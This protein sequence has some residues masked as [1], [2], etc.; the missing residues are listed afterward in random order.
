[1]SRRVAIALVLGIAAAALYWLWPTG[2]PVPV[3]DPTMRA[4]APTANAATPRTAEGP[5]ATVRTD[6]PERVAPADLGPRTDR[7]AQGLRGVV[8][9]ERAQ[10]LGGVQVHLLESAA[11]DPLALPVLMQQQLPMGPLATARSAADGTFAI[12]LAH[13]ED[14]VY[15]LYL[16]APGLAVLRLG[17]L[18]ILAD[19]WRDVG[20]VTMAEGATVRG[21]VTVEGQPIA[22]PQATVTL[23]FGSPFADLALRSLP[24][25]ER[26]LTVT[27]DATGY[28]EL[29][30][31]PAR[32][33]VRISAVAPGFARV[34]RS[35]VALSSQRP[36]QIDFALPPGLAIAGQIVDELA[37]PVAGARVEAWPMRGNADPLTGQS[38]GNGRFEVLGMRSGNYRLRVRTP[39]FCDLDVPDVTAGRQD[40]RI[41]LVRRGRIAVR[42]ATPTGEAVRR[43][44]LAVRRVVG[45]G[46]DQIT[47]LP[48]VPEQ[49]VAL[50]LVQER[51]VVPGLPAGTFQLQVTADGYARSLS[52]RFDI[53]PGEGPD[54][55]D[56]DVVLTTGA[57]LIG[58]VVDDTGQPVAGA[59]VTAQAD[60]ADPENPV[61]RMLGPAVAIAATERTVTSA[62]DGSF[63]LTRLALATYQL[64]IAHPDFCPATERGLEL[65]SAMPRSLPPVRLAKG[66]IVTGRATSAGQAGGQYKVVLNSAKDPLGVPVQALRMETTSDADGRFRFARRVPP[67]AYELRAAR[68]DTVEPEAQV[69]HQ[70]KQLQ[71]SV[72]AVTVA[73][74]QPVVEQDLDIPER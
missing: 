17:G 45:P 38:D 12:G 40:V 23:E 6:A 71:R 51:A 54:P 30:Q 43:Y 33:V 5:Q 57:S 68:I 10:P 14:R 53:T 22:V 42:V 73:K 41:Q 50:D 8:V 67:G 44:T 25:L 2:D 29:R 47:L 11:N 63:E 27:V 49:L 36:S 64:A 28:Y 26:G 7:L 62:A 9:D 55:L 20:T 37:A 15:E 4:A 1:M 72:T 48:D 46:P 70:L 52:P 66:T 35:N 21:R 56:I 59:T 69:F 3:G 39:E 24:G 18:R 19:E 74:G 32:G 13:A 65:S 34:T 16:Q 58:R 31:A 61:Y 60:G